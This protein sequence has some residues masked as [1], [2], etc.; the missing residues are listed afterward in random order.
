MFQSMK[1]ALPRADRPGGTQSSQPPPA[2]RSA[3][4]WRSLVSGLAPRSS[5][6]RPTGSGDMVSELSKSAILGR[7]P[8]GKAG[9]EED[10]HMPDFRM[11]PLGSIR[12]CIRA[13][14]GWER[15]DPAVAMSGEVGRSGP[16]QRNRRAPGLGLRHRVDP[17]AETAVGAARD[18]GTEPPRCGV[19][20]ACDIQKA[21]HRTLVL[22]CV[23]WRRGVTPFPK[24]VI[25]D[26][27][28][29]INPF[30][31]HRAKFSGL[32]GSRA[33]W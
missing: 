7:E 14:L 15:A 32:Q 18:K 19:D 10:L 27:A 33:L 17:I 3:G 25:R 26:P 29:P 20:G 16:R 30:S 12:T 28:A 24:Q 9:I 23:A 6:F 21:F 13:P 22:G 31:Q 1:S 2:G 4:I 11:G 5:T 8:T